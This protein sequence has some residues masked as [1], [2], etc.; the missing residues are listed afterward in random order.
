VSRRLRNASLWAGGLEELEGLLTPSPPL[1]K[2][3]FMLP[4][5]ALRLLDMP[6]HGDEEE[7]LYSPPMSES[8]KCCEVMI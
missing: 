5:P 4:E 8:S 6:P 1:S 2:P 3:V 7:L